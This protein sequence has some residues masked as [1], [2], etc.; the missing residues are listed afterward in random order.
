MNR[1]AP[2]TVLFNLKT[3]ESVFSISG[4]FIAAHSTVCVAV[5]TFEMKGSHW[6]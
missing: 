2:V 5:L 1:S 6:S 4:F 3:L